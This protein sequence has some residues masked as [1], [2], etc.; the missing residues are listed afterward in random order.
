MS[1]PVIG[2]KPENWFWDRV[3]VDTSNGRVTEGKFVLCRMYQYPARH[4]SGY[5]RSWDEQLELPDKSVVVQK[6]QICFLQIFTSLLQPPVS[7]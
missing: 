2:T 3:Y 5:D 4:V 6:T 1:V 7:S